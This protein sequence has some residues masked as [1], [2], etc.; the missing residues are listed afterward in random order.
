MNTLYRSVTS[1]AVNL[2][3]IGVSSFVYAQDQPQSA[4]PNVATSCKHELVTENFKKAVEVAS[5]LLTRLATD[6]QAR[7]FELLV[8]R[9]SA[10]SRLGDSEAGEK[11]LREAL[12]IASKIMDPFDESLV[13]PLTELGRLRLAQEDGD[14]AELFLLRAKDITHRTAGIYNVEQD[15]VLDDLTSAYMLQSRTQ[16][17]DRQQELR[18]RAARETYGNTPKIIEALHNYASWNASLKRFPKVRV[19][20]EEAVEILEENYGVNDPRLIDTLKLRSELYRQHPTISTPKAGEEAMQ[21]VVDIYSA[22]EYVDQ[23]D[24]LKART[25]LGDWY[26][27][28]MDE[29]HRKGIRYYKK[30]V[31]QAIEDNVDP[32]LIDKFYGDPELVF[33]YSVQRTMYGDTDSD[34]PVV[35][36]KIRVRYTVGT[37]GKTRNIRFIED[38]VNNPTVTDDIYGRVQ[39]ALFRPR[40]VNGKAVKTRNVEQEFEILQTGNG[41]ELG[42]IF[43]PEIPPQ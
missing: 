40:F 38:T 11:D 36:G 23:V 33:F 42:Q 39:S 25:D 7:R 19:A 12:R 15:E 21:R 43:A 31:K 16:Q 3:L 9:G 30:S 41:L 26:L 8:C 35:S 32:K 28:G 2:A 24:L 17:A 1:L 10:S 27:L 6:S 14:E 34:E 20:L 4:E 13:E 22:Q 37:N 29:T 5:V 18:L